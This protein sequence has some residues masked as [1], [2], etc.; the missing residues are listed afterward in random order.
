[1][2]CDNLEE[3]DGVRSGREVQE[4]GEM[5]IPLADSCWYMVETNTVLQSNYPP[6]KNNKL[7]KS[8]TRYLLLASLLA[9]YGLQ[10]SLAF[11]VL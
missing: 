1:M 10:Q 5:C 6:I 2:L 9:S 7:K 4:R 8:Q 11:L 3:W